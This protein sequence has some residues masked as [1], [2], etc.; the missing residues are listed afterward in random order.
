MRMKSIFAKVAVAFS[1]LALLGAAPAPH[2]VNHL[3]TTEHG[4]RFGNPEAPVKLVEWASYTCPHC[5]HFAM[6]G[7]AAH[8]L[9]YLPTGKV[10]FEIRPFAR[11]IVD[12]AA[13]L[14]AQCGDPS[15]FK[16]NHA[17]LMHNQSTWLGKAQQLNAE[18]QQ[19]WG[20]GPFA[21]RMRAIAGDL[22]L[23]ELMANNNYTVAE[24]DRCLADEPAAKKIAEQT[25]ADAATYGIK[26]TPSFAINGKLVEDAYGWEA[27]WPALDAALN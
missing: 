7:D 21:A 2:W 6:E 8:D 14:L 1:A 17:L 26:G 5:A 22:D 9:A 25:S 4:H 12:I 13:S 19:R 11:N 24:L 20:S 18:Q 3:E 16:V 10:S 27:L 15:R 23:Y